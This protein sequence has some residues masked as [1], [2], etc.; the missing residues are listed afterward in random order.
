MSTPSQVPDFFPAEQEAPDFIPLNQANLAAHAASQAA[1]PAPVRQ[2]FFGALGSDLMGMAQ[3]AINNL[4]MNTAQRIQRMGATQTNDL[5]RQAAG[6]PFIYRAPAAIAEKL[7]VNVSGMEQAATAGDPSGVL[8]HAIAMPAVTAATAGAA[9]VV[10]GTVGLRTR[11]G[12]AFSGIESKIGDAPINH[13][14]VLNTAYKAAEMGAKGFTLPKVVTDF[15]DWAQAVK[16]SQTPFRFADARDFY[17]SLGEKIPWDQ[18]GGK[19]GRMHTQIMRMRSQLGDALKSTAADNGLKGQYT[20]AL[21]DYRR[22]GQ[23]VGGA[24]YIGSAITAGPVGKAIGLPGGDIA[25]WMMR[26]AVNAGFRPPAEPVIGSMVRSVAPE[27]KGMSEENLNAIRQGG[28]ATRRSS[29]EFIQDI[30]RRQGLPVDPKIADVEAAL[31]QRAAAFQAE[32][33]AL[34]PLELESQ[35]P[36]TTSTEDIPPSVSYYDK[37]GRNP[38]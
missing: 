32:R 34:G 36:T 21:K 22:S 31:R 14:P 3:G 16:A 29:A 9:K 25:A 4:S 12:R 37:Y 13:E 33:E 1:P 19:G 35:K 11:A 20:Q 5:A 10:G 27:V 23:L 17:T 28:E 8:G 2:G 38:K 26:K 15:I 24:K 18:Y 7:G 6:N 30:I